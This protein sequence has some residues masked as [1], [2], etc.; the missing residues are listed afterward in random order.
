[1]VKSRTIE[2]VGFEN[3]PAGHNAMLAVMSF[4]GYDIEDAIVLNRASVDRGFGRC[5]VLKKDVTTLQ[6]YPNQTSDAIFQP[7]KDVDYATGGP[8]KDENGQDM[9][10]RAHRCLDNDGIVR[11]GERVTPGN[12]LLNRA[13][14][15]ETSKDIPNPT[16]HSA[17]AA[18]DN[19]ISRPVRY[20]SPSHG[21][22]DQVIITSNNTD[23]FMVKILMR[24]TRRPELGDKFSSRHGQKGVVGILIPRRGYAFQRPGHLP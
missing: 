19:Y 2:M 6:K 15:K 24:S 10:I 22:V 8:R 13:V 9:N 7:Q 12:V 1:M 18:S 3:L 23:H 5:I 17:A 20:K 11:P 16:A 4:S 14:P 21:H